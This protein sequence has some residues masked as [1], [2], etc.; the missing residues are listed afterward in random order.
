VAT[1]KPDQTPNYYFSFGY[2]QGWATA[3]LLEQAV[4]LGSLDRDGIVEA[5]NSLEALKFDGLAGDYPYGPP[6]ARDPSRITTVFE[7]DPNG[8][9]GLNAVKQNFSSATAE[10]YEF[11]TSAG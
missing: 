7:V 6:E 8:P 1:Y 3:Q 5:M 4:Q 10:A 11:P 2:L 9:F